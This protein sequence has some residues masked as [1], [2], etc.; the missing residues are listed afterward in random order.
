MVKSVS[1]SSLQAWLILTSSKNEEKVFL[2]L[3]LKYL[4]NELGLIWIN[5]AT[6]SSL[7]GC[8]N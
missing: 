8:L 1:V 6:S 3:V 5:A 7:T 2:V 4:Q